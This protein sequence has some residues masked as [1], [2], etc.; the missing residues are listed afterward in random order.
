[1]PKLI[2]PELEVDIKRLSKEHY[3][4][5]EIKNKLKEEDVDVSIASICRVINNIGISRQALNN[6]EKKTQISK[7]TYQENSRHDR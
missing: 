5:R 3:S 2:K 1:M 6:G 7:T 4:Y